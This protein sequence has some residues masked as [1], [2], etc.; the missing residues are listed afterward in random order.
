MLVVPSYGKIL[1]IGSSYTDNALKGKVIIQEKLDGSMFG[2]GVNENRELVARSKGCEQRLDSHDKMFNN[3]IDYIKSIEKKIIVL[4]PDS[5][6]YCEY[7]Q[8]PKHNVLAYKKYPKNYLCLR[9][10]LSQKPL[11]IYVAD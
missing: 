10:F 6:F 5:Y 1:T 2:F 9:C 11:R 4:T 3:G 7:I 8:K